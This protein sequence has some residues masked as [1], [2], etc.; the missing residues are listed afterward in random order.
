MFVHGNFGLL[1]EWKFIGEG[2]PFHFIAQE[3]LIHSLHLSK[4][5]FMQDRQTVACEG[6]ERALLTGVNLGKQA[7]QLC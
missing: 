6:T 3:L 2:E 4:A 1:L 7:E 5:S